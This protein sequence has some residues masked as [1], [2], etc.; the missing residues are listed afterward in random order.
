MKKYLTTL[1]CAAML[2]G[3]IA[4]PL[5]GKDASK[6]KTQVTT[7]ADAKVWIG[8]EKPAEQNV[9]ITIF[10]DQQ[11][12]VLHKFYPKGHTSLVQKLDVKGLYDGE[13]A[14][15]IRSGNEFVKKNFS[16][17]T[18]NITSVTVQ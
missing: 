16:V 12:V 8:V 2:S 18:S 7:N 10:D 13:Y 14:L 11:R 17:A 4:K 9:L 3:A 1:M 5:D 6:L 15:Y